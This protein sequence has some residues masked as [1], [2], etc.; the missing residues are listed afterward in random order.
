MSQKPGGPLAG[1]RV[2]E[3]AALG[4]TAFTAM[5]LAD[6]G[7][8][9][10]RIDRSTGPDRRAGDPKLDL[11]NRGR[12]ALALDLKQPAGRAIALALVGRADLL[13]EGFRPGVMERLGLGPDDCQAANQGLIYARLTGWGQDGPLADKAGHDINYIALAG[14]LFPLGDPQ[15]PPPP[16][17]N[18]V[19]DYGGGAMFAVTGILAALVERQRS[20][21]GQVVDI[22]MVDGVSLL[23]TQIYGWQAMGFWQTR[24]A[25]NLLDGGAYFYR[26][27]ATRDGRHIAVGAIEQKFHDAFLTG[28]GLDS[29][30][31]PDLLDRR[32]W[33]ERS[34]RIAAIVATRDYADWLAL[35]DKLDAC[36]SPVLSPDEAC[37]H[38][39]NLA[40]RVHIDIEGVLQPAPA[41]RFGRTPTA[42][43]T[44]PELPETTMEQVL[45]DWGITPAA[46]R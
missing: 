15:S 26:C 8:T 2:V 14:A 12:R 7:A 17:L 29:A 28:L 9:I 34:A 21:R 35:F 5:M 30:D 1:I 38:P 19:A 18:L 13:V 33:A 11:L 23:L 16:P 20:G 32:Y 43:P 40:R 37:R 4:P 42:T 46:P 3:F 41:P 6:L 24:R 22:A 44:P 36:V 25:A 10:V 27:Y 45:A 31:F 39:A